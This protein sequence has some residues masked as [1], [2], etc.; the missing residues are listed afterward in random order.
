M[1]KDWAGEGLNAEESLDAND[2]ELLLL[3]VRMKEISREISRTLCLRKIR[4]FR[5]KDCRSEK[6][7][8]RECLV[9][10]LR[11]SN[12]TSGFPVSGT[13]LVLGV[14]QLVS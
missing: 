3:C 10:Y 9:L 2:S 6:F 14:N 4:Y 1:L 5:V 12:K 13:D 7:P 11:S 8:V